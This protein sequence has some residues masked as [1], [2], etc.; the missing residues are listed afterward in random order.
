MLD[1]GKVHLLVLV[2]LSQGLKTFLKPLP[3]VLE[4]LRRGFIKLKPPLLAKRKEKIEKLLV[5]PRSH[6]L[7]RLGLLL[8]KKKVRLGT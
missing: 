8:G 1:E 7:L 6:R 5:L 4:R 3:L 2:R